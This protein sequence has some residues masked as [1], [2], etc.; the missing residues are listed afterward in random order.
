MTF[1]LPSAYGNQEDFF[2]VQRSGFSPQG[3]PPSSRRNRVV[4]RGRAIAIICYALELLD[5]HDHT[6]GNEETVKEQ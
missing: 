6:K 4:G 3:T 5:E 2:L 1:K